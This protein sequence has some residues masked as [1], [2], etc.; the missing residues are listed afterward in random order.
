MY[1][2]ILIFF[3]TGIDTLVTRPVNEPSFGKLS[4]AH[5]GN[6]GNEPISSLSRASD[7][8]LKTDSIRLVAH[9]GPLKGH[10]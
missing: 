1:F 3:E 6:K 9:S 2:L 10:Y 7:S 5:L 8:Q 4:P